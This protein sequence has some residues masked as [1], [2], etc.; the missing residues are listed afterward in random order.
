M[1]T[2]SPK[3]EETVF[4]LGKIQPEVRPAITPWL[5]FI[6]AQNHEAKPPLLDYY[7]TL[8]YFPQND[9]KKNA[10]WLNKQ[11]FPLQSSLEGM[12]RH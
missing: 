9:K 1:T 10:D 2:S 8:Q 3:E 4:W 7:C 6:Q 5:P 12:G 11:P